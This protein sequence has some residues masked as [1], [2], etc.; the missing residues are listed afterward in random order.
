MSAHIPLIAAL[1]AA[2]LAGRATAWL[3]LRRLRSALADATWRAHHDPLT[4][5]L[6]RAGLA[7]AHA[8]WCE[9]DEPMIL[10]V[11]DLDRFKAVN[12][13]YG[14]QAGD[15]VLIEVAD[16]IET[17]AGRNGGIA[18]RLGGDE[19]AVLL[20]VRPEIGEA[21][22]D[23]VRSISATPIALTV[24]GAPITLTCSGRAGTCWGE[25]SDQ[26]GTLLHRADVAL[27]HVKRTHLPYDIY[28]PS[29][30]VPAGLPRRGPRLRD[31]KTAA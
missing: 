9:D 5:L 30:T 26:L 23:I 8:I 31:R 28:A 27:Y 14:H 13:T 29:M 7:T 6:N 24:D 11:V 20:P 1:V 12:D 25:P 15:D 17:A 18:A 2:V 4:G 22:H 16:R 19:F 21:V 3:Q 10:A